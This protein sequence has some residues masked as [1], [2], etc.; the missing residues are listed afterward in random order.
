MSAPVDPSSAIGSPEPEAMY[1]SSEGED[2]ENNTQRH[3]IP[4]RGQRSESEEGEDAEREDSVGL[5]SNAPSPRTSLAALRQRANSLTGGLAGRLTGSH[6]SVDL[7]RRS[8]T[9]TDAS[10]NSHERSAAHS[11]IQSHSG[12]SDAAGSRSRLSSHVESVGSPRSDP[13]FI[14]SDPHSLSPESSTLR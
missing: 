8:R 7:N 4:I 9:G 14:G 5:L 2:E 3:P 13:R 10:A 11:M 1:E 6:S 12:S